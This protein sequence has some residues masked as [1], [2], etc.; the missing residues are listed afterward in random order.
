MDTHLTKQQ[1]AAL[2]RTYTRMLRAILNISWKEH[3][4]KNRL[5]GNFHLNNNNEDFDKLGIRG[6]V[7][8][9]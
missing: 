5:Y 3:P 1:E 7:N 6:E 4:T 2:D 8:M 9:S